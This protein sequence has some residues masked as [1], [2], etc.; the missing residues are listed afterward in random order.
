LTSFGR[1]VLRADEAGLAEGAALVSHVPRGA[2]AA[3]QSRIALFSAAVSG[4]IG[5]VVS[6]LNGMASVA[7]ARP[8]Y[9]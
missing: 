9:L 1:G 8:I 5:G 2:P 6:V 7:T 4:S 3:T